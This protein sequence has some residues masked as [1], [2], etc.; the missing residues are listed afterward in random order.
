MILFPSFSSVQVYSTLA[1]ALLLWYGTGRQPLASAYWFVRSLLTSPK[2]LLFFAAMLGILQVN[3]IE[4]TLENKYGVTYD[5][6]SAI[7]G[8]EGSWQASLQSLLHSDLVTA[9]TAFFYIVVFQSVMIA[10]LGIY[11]TRKN[12]KLFYAFCVAILLNYLIA[13]PMYWFIP[14][15][16]AWYANSHI[17][18]LMLEAFPTFETDFRGLS[19]LNNCF[20]S[21]HTSISVTMALIAARSGIRRWSII[22][23]VSAAVIIFSIFYLGIHW[24]TDM[25]GGIV[26]AFCCAAVGLKVGAW[27]DHTRLPEDPS[28]SEMEAELAA[29]KSME[30]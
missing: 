26:L 20:P 8:W 25:A 23:W 17:H 30:T 5:L 13:L 4:L 7:T 21:L 2:Y 6:T 9:I 11:T 24:F 28:T 27:A 15:N 3:K 10:S 22:A 19:G 1:V 18:F 29:A 14:V 12:M 16:E